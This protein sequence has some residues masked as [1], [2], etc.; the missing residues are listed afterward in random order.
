MK[1]ICSFLIMLA[2]I[3]G[4]VGCGSGGYNPP[5]SQNLE[6]RTWYDLDAVRD[7]LAGNHTLMN[8][9][10][11]TSPG[12][13][14]LAGPTANGGKGWEPIGTDAG[15]FSGAFNGQGYEIRDLFI[16]RPGEYGVGLFGNAMGD[17]VIE[18]VGVVNATVTGA[19]DVGLLV[20]SNAGYTVSNSYSSG[21]VTGGNDVGGLVGFGGNV[22]NSYSNANVTGGNYTGGLV[23]YVGRV[24][25]S[26][27]NGDVT[28]DQFVGG[29]AGHIHIV[30]NS[31][32]NA[33]V[34]GN[35]FVGGLLGSI[36][37]NV[38]NS[39]F[40]GNVTG[41][42]VVGG[43]VGMIW[44]PSTVSN[45]YSTGSVTGN[46][47]VGGLAGSNLGTTNNSFWDTETTG[48]NTS[49][50]GTGKTTAEMQNVSTFSGA[51]WNITAVAN[52][53]TRNPS[54]IWNIVDDV[55]YPFLSWQS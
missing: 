22:S 35:V 26:Y 31:Y 9:L 41:D 46:S 5:P 28:G 30:D 54:Y 38:S 13:E 45:S 44:D 23:G 2:L 25:D 29:L 51:T 21:S 1:R 48:Q 34:T 20:G 12:Y 40:G 4:M 15:R 14:E 39:Y 8:D 47:S 50:G 17:M 27:S 24:S 32:S 42:S 37:G 11:S 49:A 16:D 6:I 53:S 18:H 36:A 55:T 43:L 33:N 19:F 10:D 7:N 52:P 3:V